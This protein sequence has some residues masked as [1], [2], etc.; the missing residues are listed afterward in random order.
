MTLTATQL[1]DQLDARL[2]ADNWTT[3]EYQ[4][5]KGLFDHLQELELTEEEEKRWANLSNDW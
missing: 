4:V 1:L 2:K 5:I 3:K